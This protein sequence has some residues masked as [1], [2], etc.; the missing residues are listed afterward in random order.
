MLDLFFG[1]LLLSQS[2]PDDMEPVRL[3][4]CRPS[5]TSVMASEVNSR[6]FHVAINVV[7]SRGNKCCFITWQ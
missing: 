7:L 4:C 2:V 3:L 1:F 6:N 5:V